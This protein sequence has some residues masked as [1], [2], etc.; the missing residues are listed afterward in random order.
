MILAF[1]LLFLVAISIY[2]GAQTNNLFLLVTRA[3]SNPETCPHSKRW[4]IERRSSSR[5]SGHLGHHHR[6]IEVITFTLYSLNHSL[7]SLS[8]ILVL[9]LYLFSWNR[10]LKVK[11]PP[12]LRPHLLQPE[13]CNF[14]LLGQSLQSIILTYFWLSL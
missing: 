12:S 11:G 14:L 9:T 6:G 1:S 8:L 2:L 4:A 5:G 7:I 10:T 3:S 13:R